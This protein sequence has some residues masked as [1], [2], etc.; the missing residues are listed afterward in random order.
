MMIISQ[1]KLR[2]FDLHLLTVL[3]TV[4]QTRN[5]TAAARRLNM[6]QPA[7]SRALTR[8]RLL[9]K[10]Q[11]FVKGP[12]GVIPTPRA[13]DLAVVVARLLAEI[14]NAVEQPT[15]DPASAD[16]VF[17]IAT[18]DYGALAAL[19][20]AM[21]GL[22]SE[23]P[24]IGIDIVPLKDSSFAELATGA[25]DFALYADD[26]APPNLKDMHL[27][28]EHY[29]SLVRAGHPAAACSEDGVMDLDAFLRHGHILV[30]VA[31]D[32]SG[33]VDDALAHRGL[34]RRVAVSLPYFSTAA[35]LATQTDLLLTLPRRAALSLSLAADLIVLAPPVELE[36]FAYRILWHPRNDTDPGAMW[37]VDRLS[38]L[39]SEDVQ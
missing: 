31:G 23:A 20:P 11:L 39:H 27:F 13:E 12:R 38:K 25:V 18:T 32:R 24:N 7:V 10:D 28:E 14:G 16:R 8:L 34:T 33:V 30:S 29:V 19:G 36:S 35:V 26:P 17:R 2:R 22:L 3:H 15:F 21:G 9:F 1:N 37:F 4:L 5:V 6:S